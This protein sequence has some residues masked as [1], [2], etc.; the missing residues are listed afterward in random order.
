MYLVGLAVCALVAPIAA[1]VVVKLVR[2]RTASRS[3]ARA[4]RL[5]PD[6]IKLVADAVTTGGL[7]AIG[8]RDG[9]VLDRL[10]VEIVPLLRG[11]DKTALVLVLEERGTVAA[12]RKRTYAASA[13]ER[14]H[15]AEMLGALGIRRALPELAR[16][17]H[18]RSEE[19]RIVAARA[20]GKLGGARAV[21]F[22]L[23]SLE[24]PRPVPVSIVSMALLHSGPAGIEELRAGLGSGSSTARAT[25]AELLGQFGAIAASD[26]LIVALADSDERTRAAAAVALGRIGSPR[27]VEPLVRLLGEI[28]T[29]DERRCAISALGAIGSPAPAELLAAMLDSN[30]AEIPRR[31]AQALGRMGDAGRRELRARSLEVGPAGA[32][33][34]EALGS[35]SDTQAT[36]R[37]TTA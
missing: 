16:L 36:R 18:D 26:D 30:E 11:A 35:D 14:A 19:V 13:L 29:I 21:P 12:A 32:H 34:R 31:A 27:A 1:S 25:A 3:L 23:A 10:V 33:A 2:E 17:L 4:T 6:A 15:A 22:L 28:V 8:T 24:E 37:L 5:R 7:P 9:R 20:L